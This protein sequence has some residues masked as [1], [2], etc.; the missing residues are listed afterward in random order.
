[1]KKGFWGDK[2][3]KTSEIAGEMLLLGCLKPDKQK[4]ARTK[5]KEPNKSKC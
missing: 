3:G 2:C 4:P 1:M 5:P